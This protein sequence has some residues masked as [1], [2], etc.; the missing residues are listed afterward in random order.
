MFVCYDECASPRCIMSCMVLQCDKSMVRNDA[1]TLPPPHVPTTILKSPVCLVIAPTRE[2]ALQSAKVVEDSCAGAGLSST[3]LYGGVPKMGQ[4]DVLRKGVS[5][6]VATPGR[7]KVNLRCHL[8][9]FPPC[10][11]LS[12]CF[13]GFAPAQRCRV[14]CRN[15]NTSPSV[16]GFKYNEG[17]C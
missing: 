9:T 2:L 10:G 16:L 12:V 6:I 13:S 17:W 3:C 5:F 15:L 1:Q 4:R 7:L 11:F 8:C 14:L